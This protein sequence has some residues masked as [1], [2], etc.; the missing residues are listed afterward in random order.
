MSQ[1]LLKKTLSI[2]AVLLIL[3]ISLRFFL[4][5]FLPFLLAAALALAAEPL[6]SLICRKTRLRRSAATGISITLALGILSLTVMVLMALLLRQLG[7]L[8]EAVPDLEDTARRGLGSLEDFL[9]R[10]AQNS[11]KSV[12]PLLKRGVEGLFSNGA[13]LIERLA[14]WL[15]GLA[16]SI[17]SRIP[18]SALGFGTWL[19][20]SF[21]ISARLPQIKAWISS[22]MPQS[23]KQTYLP[24]LRH[25]KASVFGWLTA[26]CKLMVL[27]FFVLSLGFSLLQIPHAFLWAALICL[28]DALPVL[29]TGT[30]LLPWAAVCFLQGDTPRAMGLMGTYAV[31]WLLRSVLEPRLIG[32]QLGL[33]PL[34]TLFSMYAGYRLFGLGGLILAPLLAV[35]VTQLAWRP[36]K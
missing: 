32:K 34:V 1:P 31:A 24:M 14:G 19:L 20:A 22:V 33:D 3:W 2:A 26:Q 11:P 28:V 29:G 17:L 15:L 5:V 7:H 21:M 25:M 27:T 13:A 6:V 12:Q 18:D 9:T 16:S 23:W 4:P 36:E 35:I 8:A 10:M 30:V